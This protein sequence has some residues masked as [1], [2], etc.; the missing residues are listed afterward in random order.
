MRGEIVNQRDEMLLKL[1]DVHTFPG[2]YL[3]K[4]IGP[5]SDDF[6]AKIVQAVINASGPDLEHNVSTRESSGGNHM[7]VSITITAESAEH[8]MEVYEIFGSI[9]EIK[10]ML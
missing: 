3:F 9:E 5:N 2:P 6:V 8:V 7:S 4:V 10:Y 1:N